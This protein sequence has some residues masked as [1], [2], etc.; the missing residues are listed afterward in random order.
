MT[1]RR[2]EVTGLSVSL[3]GSLV[4]R[5][6]TLPVLQP[7]QILALV[8]PNA[9][10]KSTLLR[11]LGGL[12][13]VSGTAALGGADL[14]RMRPAMRA[15]RVAYLPQ[16]LPSTVGFTV[17]EGV[18]CGLEAAGLRGPQSRDRAVRTL[19]RLGLLTIANMPLDRLSGGQR[20][21]AGL[22]QALA[23][24]PD[25]LLLDEPTSAL[26]LRRQ[27][28]VMTLV[29]EMARERAIVVIVVLHDLSFACRWAD[30]VCLLEEGRVAAAGRPGEAL[31][32]A[33]LRR[34]YGVETELGS[35]SRGRL[36]VS[37]TGVS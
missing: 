32:T 30:L 18:I 15:A 33:T 5:D 11:G 21:L 22:A 31:T 2:L 10:G 35:D 28:Q 34:V 14:T 4:V 24:E 12:V 27:L 3:G 13:P 1:E 25:V 17:L 6:V 7:G 8:G 16:T 20:Q 36:T 29:Q 23:R 19:A 9:A 26:D 37:V